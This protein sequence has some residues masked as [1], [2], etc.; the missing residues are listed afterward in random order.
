MEPENGGPLEVW[1]FLL[2]T[3]ISRFHVC[4]RGCICNLWLLPEETVTVMPFCFGGPFRFTQKSSRNDAVSSES[5]WSSRSQTQVM[6]TWNPWFWHLQ[7]H[8]RDGTGRCNKPCYGP[9]KCWDGKNITYKLIFLDDFSLTFIWN[10]SF[11]FF[12]KKPF[13]NHFCWKGNEFFV[14]LTQTVPQSLPK[15]CRP[16]QRRLPS[17]YGWEMN[18]IFCCTKNHFVCL[19]H[20]IDVCG[21]SKGALQYTLLKAEYI[22]LLHLWPPWPRMAAPGS[23][24][25]PGE[26]VRRSGLSCKGCLKSRRHR[27]RWRILYIWWGFHETGSFKAPTVVGSQRGRRLQHNIVLDKL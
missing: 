22:H 12:W 10:I 14:P 1:R 27:H 13:P 3:I 25:T 23:L 2:E 15:K 6:V 4:F 17:R 18:R 11:F 5:S 7:A 8:G 9:R 21:L 19:L 20:Q 26:T 16:G 24:Q